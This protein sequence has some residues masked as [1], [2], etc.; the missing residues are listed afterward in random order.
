[1]NSFVDHIEG[2]LGPI[3]H[4]WNRSPTGD[5]L[6]FQII[7]CEGETLPGVAAYMTLG[8]SNIPLRST[9]TGRS[10]FIELL[11]LERIQ[12]KGE[13]T[14][15][16]PSR[17]QQ[18]AGRFIESG[19]APLRGDLIVLGGDRSETL[20][21]CPPVYYPESFGQHVDANGKGIAIAWLAPITLAEAEF[22]RTH[23]WS[24]FE[25]MLERLDPDLLD[26]WRA[27]VV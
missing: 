26:D 15:S 7:E 1:M 3:K 9:T 11:M 8:L 22:V 23:G 17:L 5:K 16:L 25:A 14:I 24:K 13:E 18:I 2:H 4:G 12:G 6:S 27:S 20:Y 21:V 19:G 10:L